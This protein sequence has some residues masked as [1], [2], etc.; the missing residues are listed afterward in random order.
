MPTAR[1]VRADVEVAT[2]WQPRHLLSLRTLVGK[3]E[4]RPVPRAVLRRMIVERLDKP[5][6]VSVTELDCNIHAGDTAFAQ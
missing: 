4:A 6:T 5:P 2:S 3:D 1:P